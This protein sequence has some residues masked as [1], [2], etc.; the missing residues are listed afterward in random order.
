MVDNTQEKSTCTFFKK[1][2]KH[3]QQRRRRE[4]SSDEGKL[5]RKEKEVLSERNKLSVTAKG[6]MAQH[7][8][9]GPFI[10]LQGLL[11]SSDI[12][13]LFQ[14]VFIPRSW[15]DY[16]LFRFPVYFQLK[17]KYLILTL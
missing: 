16:V 9:C 14:L 10:L 7:F 15:F 11:Q 17:F 5:I 1:K 13:K 4:S 6:P 12:L 8:S 2:I 3:R